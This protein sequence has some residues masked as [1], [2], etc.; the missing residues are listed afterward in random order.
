M[1][2]A[3]IELCHPEIADDRVKESLK[4]FLAGKKE[5]LMSLNQLAVTKGRKFVRENPATEFKSKSPFHCV[6]TWASQ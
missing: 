4:Y 2:G 5:S 1:F 6:P 3:F